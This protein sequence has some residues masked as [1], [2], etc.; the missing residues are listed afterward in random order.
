[1]LLEL[2]KSLGR[3]FVEILGNRLETLSLDLKE[4]RIRLVSL[5]MLGAI[6]FFLMS[7]GIIFAVFWLVVVFWERNR[8]LVIGIS[9]VSFAVVGA[10]LMV[11]LV[12]RI[13]NVRGAFESTI[14]EFNKDREALGGRGK[15][16]D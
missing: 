4:D 14:S 16:D 2:L 1:M 6:A 10:A 15:K 11:L 3:N 8:Y 12:V 9:T 13:K 5:L 7:L